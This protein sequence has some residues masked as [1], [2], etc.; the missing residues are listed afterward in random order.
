M[1]KKETDKPV[2]QDNTMEAK[3]AVAGLIVK[4]CGD[5]HSGNIRD[6]YKTL[7]AI[8]ALYTAIK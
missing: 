3:N 7:E 2:P 4:M 6:E 1:T 8:A 5:I